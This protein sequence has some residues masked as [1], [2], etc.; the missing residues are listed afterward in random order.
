VK[1]GDGVVPWRFMVDIA[2]LYGGFSAFR[3]GLPSITLLK[4]RQ[5]KRSTEQVTLMYHIFGKK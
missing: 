5:L 3:H 2:A 1:D 4:A